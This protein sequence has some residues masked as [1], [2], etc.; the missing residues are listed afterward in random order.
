MDDAAAQQ[1][2]AATVP[3]KVLHFKNAE[4][5]SEQGASK[6]VKPAPGEQWTPRAIGTRTAREAI[7]DKDLPTDSPAFRR[8]IKAYDSPGLSTKVPFENMGDQ[9]ELQDLPCTVV[10]GK[11]YAK[12]TVS[13][14]R[15][16]MCPARRHSSTR[17]ELNCGID[18]LCCI[19]V[20]SLHRR[21]LAT[22]FI[23]TKV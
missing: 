9:E 19:V 14:D 15:V 3:V 18:R 23:L 17:T 4:D 22:L 1:A 21:L 7:P 12:A 13:C 16:H 2:E 11:P 20:F 8:V 6:L 5:P 10:P